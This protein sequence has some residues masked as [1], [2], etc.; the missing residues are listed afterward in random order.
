MLILVYSFFFLHIL[1][2]IFSFVGNVSLEPASHFFLF[3]LTVIS[4]T[5]S[6]YSILLTPKTLKKITIIISHAF[7]PGCLAGH[8]Q[9][10]M[11][12]ALTVLPFVIDKLFVN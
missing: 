7:V 5:N 8:E 3:F 4:R 1:V 6:L 12:N 2:Y 10:G 11:I 9:S